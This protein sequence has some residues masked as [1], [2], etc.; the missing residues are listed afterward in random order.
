MRTGRLKITCKYLC[1][2]RPGLT[3]PGRAIVI[4]YFCSESYVPNELIG[5]RLS[6]YTKCKIAPDI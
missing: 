3:N 1:F 6:G 2:A 5:Q 4:C